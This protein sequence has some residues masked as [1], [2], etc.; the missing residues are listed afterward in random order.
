[1]VVVYQRIA[2]EEPIPF[3]NASSYNVPDFSVHGT[4]I[5]EGMLHFPS[6]MS[7]PP[8]YRGEGMPS[9]QTPLIIM[10][11]VILQ[12]VSGSALIESQH[13]TG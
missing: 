12:L 9:E 4:G 13:H 11:I 8:P 2:I 5:L 6:S 1:M 3:P 7:A 10:Q